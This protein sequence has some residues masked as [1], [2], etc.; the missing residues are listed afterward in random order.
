MMLADLLKKHAGS[1]A[2]VS[3][4]S[5]TWDI[6]AALTREYPG[7]IDGLDLD[8]EVT[9]V[10]ADDKILVWILPAFNP[11]P[12]YILTN[13]PKKPG[14]PGQDKVNI[15]FTVD[16]EVAARLAA[17][18]RGEGSK[19]VNQLLRQYFGLPERKNWQAGT[20]TEE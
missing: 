12:M 7:G 9:F 5:H 18:P 2:L 1:G 3:D 16:R 10:Q 17:F 4:G 20:G 15:G 13:V 6:H 8:Q 19:T 14:R 11:E